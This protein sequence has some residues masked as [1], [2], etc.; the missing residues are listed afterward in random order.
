MLA[1]ERA[2]QTSTAHERRLNHVTVEG[3]PYAGTNQGGEEEGEE[4]ED[5]EE[6]EGEEGIDVGEGDEENSLDDDTED[7]G[8]EPWKK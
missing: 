4:E 2:E 6:E 7:E 1:K 5:E 8:D 3:H